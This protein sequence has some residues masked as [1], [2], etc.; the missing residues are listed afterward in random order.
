MGLEQRQERQDGLSAGHP[1]RHRQG[2][3]LAALTPVLSAGLRC[4]GLIPFLLEISPEI[5]TWCHGRLAAADNG[6]AICYT[7]RLHIA[8]RVYTEQT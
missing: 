1:H 6:H 7:I 4:L 2:E 3:W 5:H 8:L